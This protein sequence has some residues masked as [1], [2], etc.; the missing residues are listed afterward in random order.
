MLVHLL[1]LL[2]CCCFLKYDHYIWKIKESHWIG[3]FS[4]CDRNIRSCYEPCKI[5]FGQFFCRCCSC[6]VSNGS[7]IKDEERYEIKDW[8]LFIEKEIIPITQF[9][10]HDMRQK[11]MKSRYNHKHYCFKNTGERCNRSQCFHYETIKWKGL[12]QHPVLYLLVLNYD[13][14]KENC[15]VMITL[16]KLTTDNNHLN[17]LDNNDS[18]LE[19]IFKVITK[20]ILRESTEFQAAKASFDNKINNICLVLENFPREYRSNFQEEEKFT[21][22]LITAAKLQNSVNVQR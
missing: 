16:R 19:F 9:D 14:T 18:P 20:E 5:S 11:F 21:L 1:L 17:W 10:L 12:L 4:K 7:Q 2:W 6:K 22:E 3:Q 13:D 8:N 15:K